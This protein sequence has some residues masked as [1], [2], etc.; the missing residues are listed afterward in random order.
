MREDAEIIASLQINYCRCNLSITWH[1]PSPPGTTFITQPNA[2]SAKT[3]H[4]IWFN[5][6]TVRWSCTVCLERLDVISHNAES[7]G[8]RWS[9]RFQ[10]RAGYWAGAQAC[11]TEETKVINIKPWLMSRLEGL[12]SDSRSAAE[13]QERNKPKALIE[14]QRGAAGH[15][16]PLWD[17]GGWGAALPEC[18]GLGVAMTSVSLFL[19]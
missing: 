1:K 13:S 5:L 2:N 15:A 18:S 11:C 14:C 16:E 17:A 12:T 7:D 4:L 10:V 9:R 6:A 19:P 8:F 3:A